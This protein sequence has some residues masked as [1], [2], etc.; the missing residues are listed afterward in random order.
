MFATRPCDPDGIVPNQTR[1]GAAVRT[2]VVRVPR[3]AAKR[4]LCEILPQRAICGKNQ[5]RGQFVRGVSAARLAAFETLEKVENQR[6]YADARF[7]D[8]VRR[9][10]LDAR[11]RALLSAPVYGVP[12]RRRTASYQLDRA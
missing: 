12:E 7:D 6:A 9:H 8:A 5:E 2:D 4:I 3:V 10:N 1:G 11:G